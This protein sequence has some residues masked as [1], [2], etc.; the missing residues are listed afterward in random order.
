MQRVFRG[1][2]GR[3]IAKFRRMERDNK[4]VPC[5]ARR[6]LCCVEREEPICFV[7]AT[8]VLGRGCT[9]NDGLVTVVFHQPRAVPPVSRG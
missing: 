6:L 7:S 4:Y 1:Y 8:C 5:V 2:I 9:G 3:V